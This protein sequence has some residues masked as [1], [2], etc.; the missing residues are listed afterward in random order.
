MVGYT[1]Q[2]LPY[3]RYLPLFWLSLAFLLGVPLAAWLAAPFWRW[4]ALA[5]CVLELL[6]LPRRAPRL[7]ARLGNPELYTLFALAVA[8][9][10]LGALRFQLT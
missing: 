10:F 3:I 8:S 1:V 5:A 9:L 6:F 2:P 7:R 4:L